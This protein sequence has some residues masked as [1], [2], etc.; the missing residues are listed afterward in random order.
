MTMHYAPWQSAPILH[1]NAR[2]AITLLLAKQSLSKRGIYLTHSKMMTTSTGSTGA[3]YVQDYLYR[4]TSASDE[5]P[6][7]S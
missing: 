1:V 5:N 6:S 3:T 7:F 2:Y 4:V